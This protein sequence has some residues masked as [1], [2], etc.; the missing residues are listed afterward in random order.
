MLLCQIIDSLPGHDKR[1]DGGT[2]MGKTAS[3]IIQQIRS[4]A[5]TTWRVSLQLGPRQWLPSLSVWQGGD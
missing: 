1:G 5:T 3:K 2:G 4:R